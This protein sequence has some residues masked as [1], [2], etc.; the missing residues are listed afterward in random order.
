[1]RKN[2]TSREGAKPQ[3]SGFLI[4]APLRLGGFAGNLSAFV[5]LQFSKITNCDLKTADILVI[6]SSW[7]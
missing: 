1:M 6:G 5:L 7:I 4:F 3:R 2:K